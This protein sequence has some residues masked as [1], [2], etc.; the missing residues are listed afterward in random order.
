[1]KT[2]VWRLT[3]R[4]TSKVLKGGCSPGGSFIR[5]KNHTADVPVRVTHVGP[6]G[7]EPGGIAS[8]LREYCSWSWTD[9]EISVLQSYSLTGRLHSGWP[10][11]RT[12]C[13]LI[14]LPK[15]SLGVIHVHL[16]QRGAFIREGLL[17]LVAYYRRLPV[18]A[19]IHGSS[20][21]DFYK[22]HRSLC[23]FVLRHARRVFVLSSEVRNLLAAERAVHAVLL[24]NA[25][26]VPPPTARQAGESQPT[27]VFAGEVSARKGADILLSAWP[28]VLAAVPGAQCRV[29]GPRSRSLSLQN[30][31]GLTFE[32]PMPQESLLLTLETCRVAVLPSRAEAMP[33]FVLE[34]MARGRPVVATQVGAIPD[35]VRPGCGAV[36]PVGDVAALQRELMHYLSNRQAAGAD[37][38]RARTRVLEHH[39][40]EVLQSRLEQEWMVLAKRVPRP[41]DLTN[42]PQFLGDR[43]ATPPLGN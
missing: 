25:V 39:S 43:Y 35:V 2:H 12:L 10:F 26:V 37:G 30:I 9:C 5:R 41:P 36:V 17:L 16:S 1:M 15:R 38:A 33:M 21:E 7:A 8:V 40:V 13:Q 4:L 20:F 22:A 29:I 32:G 24:P 42:D 14:S 31:E 11:I 27:A 28:D 3:C 18:C 19:S 6:A 34:A 23:L